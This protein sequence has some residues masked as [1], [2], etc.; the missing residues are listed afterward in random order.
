MPQKKQRQNG[1]LKKTSI[2]VDSAVYDTFKQL[3]KANHS[4][5]SKEIRKFMEEYIAREERRKHPL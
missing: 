1:Q 3:A 4:D 5:A 2:T